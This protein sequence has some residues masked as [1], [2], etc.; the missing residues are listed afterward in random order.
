M[1]S[2]T[3]KSRP[4]HPFNPLEHECFARFVN[5]TDAEVTAL[6]KKFRNQP[7]EYDQGDVVA[8]EYDDL[9]DLAA[10]ADLL[11]QNALARRP[12][13]PPT[14]PDPCP[15]CA[16]EVTRWE[17][18]AETYWVPK[19]KYQDVVGLPMSPEFG[20]EK[21]ARYRIYLQPCGHEAESL[22]NDDGHIKWVVPSTVKSSDG[23]S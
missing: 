16:S 12:P 15:F 10:I 9:A 4:N 3:S 2:A 6:I 13:R 19:D 17:M 20:E 22:V 7:G 18:H 1:P 21:V 23:A 14:L 5:L 11:W 8:I